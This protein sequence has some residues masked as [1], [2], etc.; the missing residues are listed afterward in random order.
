MFRTAAH[1]SD[2]IGQAEMSPTIFL[3][4]HRI[5]AYAHAFAGLQHFTRE[6]GNTASAPGLKMKMRLKIKGMIAK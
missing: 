3:Q 4:H 5:Y 1:K 6:F 2:K